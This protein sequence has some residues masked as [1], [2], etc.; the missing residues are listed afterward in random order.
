MTR[1][2]T[3]GGVCLYENEQRCHSGHITIKERVCD[4]NIEL[5][6]VSCRPHYLPREFSN[7]IVLVVYIPPSTNVESE[8]LTTS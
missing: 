5:L 1:K 4:K 2:R 6:V 7:V 3:G 8:L